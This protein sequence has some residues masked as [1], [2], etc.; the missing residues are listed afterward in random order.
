MR[1]ADGTTWMELTDD[2]ETEIEWVDEDTGEIL[3]FFGLSSEGEIEDNQKYE[4]RVK[5]SD[6][7]F[8]TL[9]K[10]IVNIRDSIVDTP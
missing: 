2:V 10:G 1:S 4:L 7:S 9:E 3:I 8:I 6:G 5:F